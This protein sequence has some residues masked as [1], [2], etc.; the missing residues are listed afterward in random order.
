MAVESEAE[1]VLA[2]A[3]QLGRPAR[4]PKS[5][6]RVGGQ[7]GTTT[8][9]L[10]QPPL[11]E[12]DLHLSTHPALQY[13]SAQTWSVVSASKNRVM[14]IRADRDAPLAV[15]VQVDV[16]FPHY[17]FPQLLSGHPIVPVSLRP[18]VLAVA[19]AGFPDL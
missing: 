13:D 12:P 14:A 19:V 3:R 15:D 1:I 9:A 10:F 16:S 5:R 6:G 8:A 4:R 11:P 2:A 7:R 18:A 17:T